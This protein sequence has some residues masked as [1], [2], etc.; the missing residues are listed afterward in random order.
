MNTDE[1]GLS[2]IRVHPCSSV[3][4]S[5]WLRLRP[6]CAVSPNCIRRGVG[7]IPRV[8]VS[9]H[10]AE[11]NSAIQHSATNMIQPR[12]NTDKRRSVVIRVNPCPS[13]VKKIFAGCDD[14]GRY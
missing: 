2:L 12:M 13:V 6:R 1:D 7:S 14:F 10:L 3:V 5:Y 9:Q 8:G 4:G 11:C